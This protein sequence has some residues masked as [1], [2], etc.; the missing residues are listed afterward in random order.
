MPIYYTPN[1]TVV[2]NRIVNL[3]LFG[4]S[5]AAISNQFPRTATLT[6]LDNQL[7]FS[8]AGSV[9]QT[10][11]SGIGFNNYVLSLALQADGDLLAGGNFTFYN[12]YPIDYVARLNTDASRDSTFLVNQAGANGLVNQVLSQVPA[13]GQ[14][15]GNIMLAGGFSQVDQVNRAG[16]ARLNPDGS[17]DTTF[18]PGAG[19]DNA[20]YAVAQQFLPGAT[21]NVPNLAYYVIGGSFENYDGYPAPGVGRLTATGAVDPNFNPQAGIGGSNAAV[22]AVAIDANNRILLGGD[23]TIFNNQPHHHLVR[24]NV[25]GSL[26]SSFQAFDGVASDIN[27]S[28]R[29]LLIQPDGQILIG[30]SFTNV[31]GSNYNCVARLNTDGSV[32]TS[33]NVGA[34]CDNLVLAIALDSQNRIL[35]GGEF[36]RASGVT[37]NGITRLNPD[38]TVDPTINFG[39][40]ANGYVD[41]IV[42]QENDEINVGGG[43]TTFDGLPENNF[44]RLYGGAISG[45]GSIEFGQAVY[46]VL[47]NATNAYISIQRIGG[48]G[49]AAQPVVSAVFST[50]DGTGINGRDYI[51]TTNTILFPLGETFET[52]AIPLINNP[53]V[54]GDV[55]VNLNLTNSTYAT[56]GPLNSSSPTSTPRWPSRAAVIG[57]R[58][59]LPA[60]APSSR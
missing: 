7:V 58:P 40:G 51:G 2:T 59:T 19:A 14:T 37:R 23:F 22:R 56:I 38:G 45:D 6:I 57:N 41:T 50:S 30:G 4:G 12:Q 26:D 9:D 43:F 34:G 29:A 24:L 35:L 21:T 32:D 11:A 33:F 15:N 49:T 16:I 28:V 60:A 44:V 39:Y 47:E 13:G 5:P 10:T 46:G 3:V 1:E 54:A 8:P 17:L 25:D 48:E 52:V 42:I 31:S 20:V 18:N 55:M 53:I 27:G 36:A